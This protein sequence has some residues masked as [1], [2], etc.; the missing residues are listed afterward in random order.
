MVILKHIVG[1]VVGAIVGFF[2]ALFIG[3]VQYAPWMPGTSVSNEVNA[4]IVHLGVLGAV[5][6]AA[7]GCSISI[8][9]QPGSAVAMKIIGWT[10]ICAIG[11]LIAIPVLTIMIPVLLKVLVVCLAISIVFGVS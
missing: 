9:I 8:V 2:A 5:L 6:G 10:Y 3:I 4:R 11:L 7:L 1:L